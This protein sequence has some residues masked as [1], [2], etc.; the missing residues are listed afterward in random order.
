MEEFDELKR[1]RDET[2]RKNIIG[3]SE[4]LGI[5]PAIAA[6][7]ASDPGP[8]YCACPVGPCQHIWSGEYASKTCTRCG[9]LAADHDMRC[10]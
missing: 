5:D 8:C 9:T 4:T 10:A 6:L 7:H 2:I 1:V 3:L